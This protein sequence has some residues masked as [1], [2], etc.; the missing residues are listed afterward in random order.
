MPHKHFPTEEWLMSQ[1]GAKR[2]MARRL[3][4]IDETRL[5]GFGCA[6]CAWVFNPCGMPTGSS[7]DEMMRTFEARRDREV[8]ISC[9]RGSPKEHQRQKL[10]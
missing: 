1:A 2:R 4:W 8:F 6:E 7:L 10:N 3:V 5:R 9:L